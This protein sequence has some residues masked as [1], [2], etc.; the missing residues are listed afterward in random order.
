MSPLPFFGGWAAWWTPSRAYT[1]SWMAI[2]WR[3]HLACRSTWSTCP[4]QRKLQVRAELSGLYEGGPVA[5]ITTALT[6][7][8]ED[9]YQVLEI[10]HTQWSG[11]EDR[12]ELAGRRLLRL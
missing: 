8:F 5:D 1:W 3:C 7:D 2:H 4:D 12:I 9:W 10:P 6:V 11:Y